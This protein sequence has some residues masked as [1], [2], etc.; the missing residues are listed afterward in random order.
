MNV[1][2]V[3]MFIGS[4]TSCND[5]EFL[6]PSLYTEQVTEQSSLMKA[7]SN[8]TPK[9]W[10]DGENAD[11]IRYYH[12]KEGLR[13]W[14]IIKV[15]LP[16][17]KISPVY[18]IS[19]SHATNPT[20]YKQDLGDWNKSNEGKNS[21]ALIN[22]SFFN[23]DYKT[24]W[25]TGDYGPYG[26]KAEVAHAF[27]EDDSFI[28]KG[29]SSG[30][31]STMSFAVRNK[32]SYISPQSYSSFELFMIGYDP[33]K[34]KKDEN[35]KI[36]RTM[37]GIPSNGSDIVYFFVTR[38]D[39]FYG[40][41]QSEAVNALKDFG[42]SRFVMLDGSASSQFYWK[43]AK[44]VESTDLGVKTRRIPVALRMDRR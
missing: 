43:G 19:S 17:V 5:D 33:S 4:L 1:V 34:E 39:S 23:F 41:K 22:A 6:D 10:T 37:I 38:D 44:M 35:L 16:K 7:K 8:T 21:I 26:R 27:G 42:C 29:Y 40:A 9:G 36:G 28:S 13:N 14:Y 18:R 32:K 15:Y 30:E 24:N 31:S 3:T 11:G 25:G 2:I 12:K 20:F